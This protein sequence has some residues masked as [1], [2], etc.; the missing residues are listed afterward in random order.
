M[1]LQI[2]LDMRHPDSVFLEV[3]VHPD[4]HRGEVGGDIDVKQSCH[5]DYNDAEEDLPRRRME[6]RLVLVDDICVA[7]S[8]DGDESPVCGAEIG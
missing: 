6:P 3:L 5:Q 1:A 8:R 4:H 2:R 7:D